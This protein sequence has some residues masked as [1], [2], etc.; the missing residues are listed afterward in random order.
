MLKTT[1]TLPV[2]PYLV[3][4]RT[5]PDQHK[6]TAIEI[7]LTKPSSHSPGEQ[8]QIVSVED[9]ERIACSLL[10]KVALAR[11]VN[12]DDRAQ[13][14]AIMGSQCCVQW[15]IVTAPAEPGIDQG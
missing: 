13:I 11:A 14:V 2:S 10:E 5:G 8:S 4:E 15:Q 9:A 7:T 12:A 6:A 3:T 1:H